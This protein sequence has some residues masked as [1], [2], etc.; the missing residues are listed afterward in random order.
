[1]SKTNQQMLDEARVALHE[2]EIGAKVV[3]ISYN[4]NATKFTAASRSR[5][6]IYIR[7]LEVKVGERRSSRGSLS[8]RF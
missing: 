3:E 5:L 2:L 7:E 4:G 1:M 6:R 8:P